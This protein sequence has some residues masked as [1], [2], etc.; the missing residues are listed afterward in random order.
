MNRIVFGRWTLDGDPDA[1]RVA[2]GSI[3]QGSPEKCGC[4]PCLN[5]AAS[6]ETTYPPAFRQTLVDLG[7]SFDREA[8]IYHNCR[9]ENGLHSYGGWFHFVGTIVS[10]ADAFVPIDAN[11]GTFDLHPVTDRFSS[12]VSVRTALVDRAFDSQVLLQL[13]FSANIPWTIEVEEAD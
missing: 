7:V 6:R 10:G 9:L 13:E 2:Y 12:G 8:E 11:S 5:F 3:S 1:T 4:G